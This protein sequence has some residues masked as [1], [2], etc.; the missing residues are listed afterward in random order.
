MLVINNEKALFQIR[1]SRCWW[2]CV[3]WTLLTFMLMFACRSVKRTVRS[4]TKV[5]YS[6]HMHYFILMSKAPITHF[7]YWLQ[8]LK[9][10]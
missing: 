9:I 3:P 8:G 6:I 7:S 10:R 4:Q 5:C 2:Q 1:L